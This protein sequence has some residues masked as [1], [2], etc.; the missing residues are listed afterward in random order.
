MGADATGHDRGF[1]Q[2]AL[3]G[4]AVHRRRHC[5]HHKWLQRD[6][7]TLQRCFHANE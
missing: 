1:R 6:F 5:L 4:Q 7:S 2:A 3:H